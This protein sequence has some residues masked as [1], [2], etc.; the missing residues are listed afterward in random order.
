MENKNENGVI[1]Q[2]MLEFLDLMLKVNNLNQSVCSSYNHA[3]DF[4][5]SKNL[6]PEF[7]KYM[8][9]RIE[10]ESIKKQNIN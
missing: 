5:E 7:N 10:K 8:I 2:Q 9:D 4:I 6:L 1:K 3:L